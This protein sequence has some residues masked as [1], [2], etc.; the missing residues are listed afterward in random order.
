[1]LR[2]PKQRWELT[3]EQTSWNS[4]GIDCYETIE[5]VQLFKHMF[6]NECGVQVPA[7]RYTVIFGS[8]A[9]AQLLDFMLWAGLKAKEWEEHRGWV[10]H[11]KIG[12][13]VLGSNF[14][15]SDDPFHDQTFRFGFDCAGKQREFF[16]I[17]TKGVLSNILYDLKTSSKYG[18][19]QTGHTLGSPSIVMETGSETAD[20]FTFAQTLDK[21][22]YIP[23][24]H[25]MNIPNPHKGICTGSSRFN[26]LMIE[27]G[28][29][30]QPIFTTRITDSFHTIF[31]NIN[32]ISRFPVSV[33]LSRTYDQRAP[34]AFS[35]PSYMVVDNV[36]ITDSAQSF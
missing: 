5:I 8:H 20:P 10:A 2:H 32:T 19:P 6:E 4:E 24:L 33:N 31:N 30:V 29:N 13:T 16:P 15:L 7:G 23:V 36:M 17:F 26:A 35:V 14:T 22:L 25:Y 27:K 11:R 9:I 21:V 12:D 1:M 18:K 3:H 34:V 28:E